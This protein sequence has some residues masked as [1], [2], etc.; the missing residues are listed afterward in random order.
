YLVGTDTGVGKT[1]LACALL[2]RA[3]HAH[4]R[5]VP[6]KP[7]QS[8]SAPPT[9]IDRLLTAAGLPPSDAPAAC[10]FRLDPP[11]APGLAEH[12]APFVGG[13]PTASSNAIAGAARALDAWIAR[14]HP[15][16]VVVEGAGGLHVP[17]PGATWQPA[18]I[19]A[20]ADH[21]VIVGRAGL[22]TIN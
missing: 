22:G 5:A 9:D 18:W 12:A 14:H 8:G 6:F 1:T 2:R 4:V 15:D 19:E 21:V 3:A 10:P 11:L 13:P 20:L 7:A 17:M 16:L